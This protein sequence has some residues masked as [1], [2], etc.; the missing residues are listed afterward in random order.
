[1]RNFLTLEDIPYELVP[2]NAPSKVTSRD[3]HTELSIVPWHSA[4]AVHTESNRLQQFVFFYCRQPAAEVARISHRIG[5]L[6]SM[7]IA[8]IADDERNAVFGPRRAHRNP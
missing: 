1:M 8:G 3:D 5:E 6:V 7:L 4:Y 2:S